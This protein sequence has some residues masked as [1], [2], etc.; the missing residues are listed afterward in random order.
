MQ[1]FVVTLLLAAGTAVATPKPHCPVQGPLF[2]A[3]KHM[4]DHPL[5]LAAIK[6]MDSYFD[7]AIIKSNRTFSFHFEAYSTEEGPYWMRSWTAPELQAANTTGVKNVDR[8]TVHR[9]GSITKT[10]T[11]MTFLSQVGWDVWNH[12]IT[13]Y[14][15][16]LKALEASAKGK[17]PVYNV[18][19]DDVTVGSLVT[20]QSGLMRDCECLPRRT[21]LP[22]HCSDI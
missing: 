1:S 19:W 21:G 9:V 22:R 8:N 16:E 3:P 4:K 17:S 5:T 15:P 12:P 14:I 7:K 10:F 20:F 2:P 13:K 11:V 6:E 18:D